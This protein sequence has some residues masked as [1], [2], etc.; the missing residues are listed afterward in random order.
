M[1]G[2]RD[3]ATSKNRLWIVRFTANDTGGLT[4]GKPHAVTGQVQ[5]ALPFV[6]VNADGTIAVLYDTFDGFDVSGF[7]IF[8]AHVAQSANDGSTFADTP[9]LTFTSPQKDNGDVRQRVL[10]DYQQMKVVGTTFYGTFTANGAAFGRPFANTDAIFFRYRPAPSITALKPQALGQGAKKATLTITGHG[11]ANG[12]TVAISGS[13]VTV[14]SVS[15]SSQAKLIA[16]VSIAPSA[17]LGQ[18]D[19]TVTNPGG[20]TGTCT[21][22]LSIQPAPAPT[23]VNP[24]AGARGTSLTTVISGSGFTDGALARFGAGITVTSTTFVDAGHL[25][26]DI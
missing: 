25:S 22:C 12:A 7:P 4:A 20:A 3:P 23:A 8:T 2:L 26:V 9:L 11:F 5:A 1:Y 14:D 15:F 24:P 10:G 21:G 19:V 13:G 6:S 18:R 16:K 17:A